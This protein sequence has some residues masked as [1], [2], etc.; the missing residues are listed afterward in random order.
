MAASVFSLGVRRSVSTAR[1]SSVGGSASR[2]WAGDLFGA[3]VVVAALDLRRRCPPSSSNDRRPSMPSRV[4]AK[5]KF[6]GYICLSIR[7][8]RRFW[9]V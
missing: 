2:T 9:G 3:V 6:L 4:T 5:K 8:S 1:S 7:C